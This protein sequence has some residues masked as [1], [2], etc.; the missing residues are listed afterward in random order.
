MAPPVGYALK[1]AFFVSV[2][3]RRNGSGVIWFYSRLK[4][5]SGVG[6]PL[7]GYLPGGQTRLDGRCHTGT[8]FVERE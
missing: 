4:N 1:L 2:E 8:A 5:S 7:C 6:V 3:W